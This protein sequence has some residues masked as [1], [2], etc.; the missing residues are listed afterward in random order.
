MTLLLVEPPD[1]EPLTAA[2]ARARLNI[3][4]GV[5]PD[6]VVSAFI[7]ASRQM[8]DGANGWLGRALITQ[9]WELVVDRFE[10]YGPP[11]EKGFY[12]REYYQSDYYY[13]GCYGQPYRQSPGIIIPLPPL[14]SVTFVKYLDV[15]GALQTLDPSVYV[16]QKGEPSHLVLA[17]G[18]SWPSISTLPG[19]VIIR[20]IAGYGDDG[21]DVPET[22]RMAIALQAQYLRSMLSENALRSESV[23]GVGSLGAMPSGAVDI[24]N[25]A[26]QTLL[27]GLR[28]WTP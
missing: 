8:I 5:V 2:E 22:A 21:S 27:A 16:V 6:L 17:N 18:Q 20:F 15:D 24:I 11:I 3:G 12:P 1:N 10:G 28:V 13:A 26:S 7:T 23:T 14:Q 19:S 4:A 25:M 9:T